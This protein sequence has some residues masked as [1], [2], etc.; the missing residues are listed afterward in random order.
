M[1][2]RVPIQLRLARDGWMDNTDGDSLDGQTKK[3]KLVSLKQNWDYLQLQPNSLVSRRRR[4]GCLCAYRRPFQ[5]RWDDCSNVTWPWPLVHTFWLLPACPRC[6]R[7]HQHTQ[8]LHVWL[9]PGPAARNS[10]LQKYY[11]LEYVKEYYEVVTKT[12]VGTI[13]GKTFF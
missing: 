12:G 11:F 9:L 7:G 6:K 2:C 4:F 13:H 3:G 8:Q 5:M 10:T 1:S